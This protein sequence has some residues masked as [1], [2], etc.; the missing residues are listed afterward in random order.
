[1]VETTLKIN[2][3]FFSIQGESLLAGKPTVFVRTATCNLR[4]TWCDTKYSYW[5]GSVMG[6]PAILEKVRSF[7]SKYV[8]LTGGEPLGQKGSIELMRELLKEGY[9]VSLETNG[10]FSIKDVPLDVVKVI[11]IKCPDSGE[12][13]Q[14]AWEN[15]DLVR[16]HDQFKFVVA[17]KKDF[18]WAQQVC[19]D[20]QLEQKCHLLYSP[21]YGKV[22][23]H[24]LAQWILDA[25]APVTLQVQLHKEIWGP[26]E[27]GV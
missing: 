21:V 23:P 22:K 2:E 14:M 11:D 3:I 6:L 8:C 13:N 20:H 18:D 1:M 5:E 19:R 10:S 26:N 16:V 27:R 7:G 25:K 24:E 15:L 4:C 12:S 9:T 17:S